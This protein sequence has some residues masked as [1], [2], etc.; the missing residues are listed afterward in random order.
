VGRRISAKLVKTKIPMPA[1]SG[2]ELLVVTP[3]AQLSYPEIAVNELALLLSMATKPNVIGAPIAEK[4]GCALLLMSV[5]NEVSKLLVVA[6]GVK[7][8]VVDCQ[9]EVP[10]EPA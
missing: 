7:V 2:T 10:P 6:P 4:S 5:P 8:I 9:P 1:G 3:I